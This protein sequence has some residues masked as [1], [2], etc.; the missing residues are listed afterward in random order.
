MP[1][2][3]SAPPQIHP[4]FGYRSDTGLRIKARALRSRKPTYG[5][6]R[7]QAIRTMIS[8][9][10]SH[11]VAGLEVR[12]EVKGPFG[13][14]ITQRAVTDEEGFADFDIAFPG[15]WPLP[16][17][18]RWE[19]VELH[20]TND[21][22]EQCVP[23]HVL[24]PAASASLGV[25]SDIDDTIIE[26]GIT[27]SPR[28]ILRNWRRI[29]A[30]HPE[31]RIAAPGADAFYSALGGAQQGLSDEPN[32]GDSLPATERPFFFVSSSPWNLFSYLVAFKK[33]KNLP[34][35]PMA[36]RDWGFNRA[37][38]GSS[39]HGG[40]KVEAIRQ[41]IEFYPA[42]RFALVG[43]DTQG[44][45]TAFAEVAETMRQRVAAIFIRKAAEAPMS[46]EELAAKAAVDALGIP[47]W[48]G[49]SYDVGRE[50]LRATGL[51]NDADANSIVETIEEEGDDAT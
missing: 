21:E 9:Y 20:W 7:W 28:A 32:A 3:P 48:V 18:A 16:M 38:L 1:L 35:G 22:G 46:P 13:E 15:D 24:A 43:D 25:I 40:H 27:G 11:E 17:S 2:F 33:S 8:H 41:I 30:Q 51:V 14:A 34:L 47:M 10:A 31:E 44:D 37:T 12:L 4:F 19:V 23:G 26:T 42:M 6:G 5:G 49:P 29:L 45:V 39:S 36:L 50:F